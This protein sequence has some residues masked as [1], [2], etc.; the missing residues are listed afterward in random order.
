MVVLI[1]QN[2]FEV[3]GKIGKTGNVKVAV[4]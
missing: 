1:T 2:D 4:P 3:K